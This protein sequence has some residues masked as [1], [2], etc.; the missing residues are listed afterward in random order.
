[1]QKNKQENLKNEVE[2]NSN[3]SKKG[4]IT[5]SYHPRI[6][7]RMH[8]DFALINLNPNASGGLGKSSV[9]TN[10]ISLIEYISGVRPLIGMA[11]NAHKST[12]EV[13]GTPNANGKVEESEQDPNEFLSFDPKKNDGLFFDAIANPDDKRDKVFDFG[14]ANEDTLTEMFDMGYDFL[15]MLPETNRIIFNQYITEVKDFATI[16]IQNGKFSDFNCNDENK[17]IFSRTFVIPKMAKKDET[18]RL[19]EEEFGHK[20][21]LNETIDLGGG[22]YIRHHFIKSNILICNNILAKFKITDIF[23]GNALKYANPAEKELLSK[24]SVKLL[25]YGYFNE[26]CFN[27]LSDIYFDDIEIMK[28]IGR[29]PHPLY[30]NG[31]KLLNSSWPVEY[32]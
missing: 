24:S 11:D 5:P 12:M 15:N 6:V 30:F 10:H 22:K 8:P 4:L 29:M 32:K 28:E 26:V 14:S 2:D 25:L 20:I 7:G 13:W 9:A 27:F 23:N 17:V 19:Y 16:R 3:N 31:T 1:M 18:M 21:N